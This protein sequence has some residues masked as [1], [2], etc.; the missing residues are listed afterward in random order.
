MVP[1][2]VV[3]VGD[4]PFTLSLGLIIVIERVCLLGLDLATTECL[5]RIWLLVVAVHLHL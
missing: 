1:S 4:S 2:L 3:I 5:L